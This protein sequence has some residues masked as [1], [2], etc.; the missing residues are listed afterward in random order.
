M[1]LLDEK[2]PTL[3]PPPPYLPPSPVSP[4]PPFPGH[5]ERLP[6]TL[7]TIPPSVLLRIVYETFTL[8]TSIEKQRKTLYWLGNSLRRVS[9]T[10]YIGEHLR[11]LCSRSRH[12]ENQT[13]LLFFAACMHVLRSTY[14]PAYTALVHPPYTSDPF[15][16]GTS[17]SSSSYTPYPSDSPVLSLQRETRILD[18]FIALKVR[19][20]VWLDDS[21]LHLERDESFRDLFDLMQPKSRLEDLVRVYGVREGVVSV[22]DP[23]V[24]MSSA[25]KGLQKQPLPVPFSLLSVTFSSR[26]VGLVLTTKERKKTIVEVERTREERLEVAAKLLV[27][28]LK[29]WIASSGGLGCSR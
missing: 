24:V 3:P 11:L 6:A 14:L 19:E 2:M 7:T 10:I 21:E 1:I 26:R 22:S 8:H 5:A 28:E 15:P 29:M 13:W 4:P 25:K 27:Q 16:H 12:A 23:A 17:S 18:L 9:R 20:D